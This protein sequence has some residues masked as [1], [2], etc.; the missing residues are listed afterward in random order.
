LNYCTETYGTIPDCPFEN[1]FD[2]T[3]LRHSDSKKWYAIAM[4]VPKS[5]FGLRG[6][7]I[8]DVVNVKIPL[9][10]NGSFK[11][12][13]GVYPAYHMNKLHWVSVLLP[14]ADDGLVQFL[15]NVSFEMTKS[16]RR[17]K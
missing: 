5:K 4:Q 15:A 2:T 6:D 8:I 16:K 9:E 17:S 10:M 12:S 7:E 14:L 13:E 11:Y 1:D 3:V